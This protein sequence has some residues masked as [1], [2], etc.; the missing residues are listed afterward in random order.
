MGGPL[1]L[2]QHSSIQ[3]WSVA[4][5]CVSTQI[6]TDWNVETLGSA[7]RMTEQRWSRCGVCVCVCQSSWDIPQPT[8]IILTQHG[9][10]F[11]SA[12]EWCMFHGGTSQENTSQWSCHTWKPID[13]LW[14]YIKGYIDSCKLFHIWP[15]F[16]STASY[17]DIDFQQSAVDKGRQ[18]KRETDLLKKNWLHMKFNRPE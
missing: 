18:S 17:K 13:L 8:V 10:Y 9:L 14:L 2:K 15:S 4:I 11:L 1:S 3:A 16:P 12:C 7:S 5:E 6:S